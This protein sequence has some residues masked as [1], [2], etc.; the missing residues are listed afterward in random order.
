[1][2]NIKEAITFE[3]IMGAV[4]ISSAYKPKLFIMYGI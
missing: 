4:K 3:Q 2:L 1:M